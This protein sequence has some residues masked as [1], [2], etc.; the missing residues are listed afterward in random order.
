M[1]SCGRFPPRFVDYESEADMA[2]ILVALSGGVDS[3]AA[4]ALLVSQGH[5]VVGV[6]LKLW[7]GESDSGCCSVSDVDDARRVAQQLDIDHHV[8][9]FGDDFDR[10]V[11]D[12]YVADH[13]N[14]RTPNPCVECNR[15]IKFDKLFRRADAL[16]FDLIATG[17]HARI[18]QD[19]DGVRRISRGAD[20]AK[21][22]SY[23]LHMLDQAQLARLSFPV[24]DITKDEVRGLAHKLG[25][26]TADKPDSQDVCFIHSEGGR[27]VFLGD[28]I[29]LRPASLVDAEGAEVGQVDS[30]ELVTLGQRKGLNLGGDAGRRYVVDIDHQASKVTVGSEADLLVTGQQ[31]DDLAWSDQPLEGEFLVQC[32][33]HGQ[34]RLATLD[35]SSI[36]W[37]QPERRVAPGQ[38]IVLYRGDDV[39]GGG[40]AGPALVSIGRSGS[41]A[42]TGN[43]SE[44][45]TETAAVDSTDR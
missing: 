7:G 29:S 11:V 42:G 10:F 21:D 25:L 45:E 38:S 28:R 12:P 39:V 9:N 37:A 41:L 26:R 27:Q 8:F 15:H 17:H 35:G 1:L 19:A 3:S 14:G 23:V 36:V 31:L 5:N 30:I 40:T 18:S 6:T 16:G 24:G 22:Q 20:E 43:S 4:A 33:A 44:L 34:P 2:D 32:S 13:Q